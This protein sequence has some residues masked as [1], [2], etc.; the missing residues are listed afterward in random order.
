MRK[1]LHADGRTGYG[2]ACPGAGWNASSRGAPAGI[3]ADLLRSR[4]RFGRAALDLRLDA[5]TIEGLRQTRSQFQNPF[6][7]YSTYVAGV[8][9]GD[10]GYSETFKR[11]V[12]ELLGD[13]Y[14]V[15]L[16]AVGTS[17]VIGWTA[18]ALLASCVS[19]FRS[20][21]MQ[22]GS[23][24]LAGMLL[25]VPSA[26][27]AF[28]AVV[29]NAPVAAAMSCV[30]FSRVFSTID[31]YFRKTGQEPYVAAAEAMGMTRSALFTWHIAGANLPQMIALAGSSVSIA[32]GAAVP[33]EVICDS[34]GIGQL[35]WRATLGRDLPVLLAV[36][37]AIAAVNTTV[38]A[39]TDVVVDTLRER[40]A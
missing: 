9:Q 17:A 40:T 3:R 21:L 13:R 7:A 15:T 30:V 31:A 39:V 11:P 29:L 18:A 32:L 23:G 20:R 35:A 22:G 28:G 37:L 4:I 10:F 12:S 26:L 5:R 16:Q 1:P 25:C 27:L 14:P 6:K 2:W 38:S 24:L 34:P 33:L 19:L 8:L 36:T